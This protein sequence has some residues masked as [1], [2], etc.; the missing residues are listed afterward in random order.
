MHGVIK[1]IA[2]TKYLEKHTS[3]RK[4]LHIFLK[5][6]FNNSKINS[7]SIHLVAVGR[8]EGDGGLL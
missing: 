8:G 5:Q 1:K 2:S 4:K 3:D 6:L 7:F